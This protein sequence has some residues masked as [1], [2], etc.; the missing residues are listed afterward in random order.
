MVNDCVCMF[1]SVNWRIFI[2]SNEPNY[3]AKLKFSTDT[4]P[5]FMKKKAIAD[6]EKLFFSPKYLK[7][8]QNQKVVQ[9]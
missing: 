9:Y 5:L 8:G 2:F 3:Q 6:F 7:D 4:I 1:C